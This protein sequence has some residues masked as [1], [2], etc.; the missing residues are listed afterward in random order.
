M[1]VQFS[2]DPHCYEQ[3]KTVM[4]VS[5]QLVF[6]VRRLLNLIQMEPNCKIY[7]CLPTI[8]D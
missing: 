6:V 5:L 8:R 2:E 3:S 7:L 1:L 4:V